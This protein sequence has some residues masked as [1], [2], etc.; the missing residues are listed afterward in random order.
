[1]I[2]NIKLEILVIILYLQFYGFKSTKKYKINTFLVI[3][4]SFLADFNL[5]FTISKYSFQKS[6]FFVLFLNS[7]A[8][9]LAKKI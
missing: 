5:L 6:A 8:R 2:C 7:G 4:Q 9:I 1:M 3:F